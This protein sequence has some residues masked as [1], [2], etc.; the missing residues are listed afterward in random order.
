VEEAERKGMASQQEERIPA[1]LDKLVAQLASE[2]WV[3]KV[4]ARHAIERQ[5]EAAV[6]M[7]GRALQDARPIVRWEAAKAL[8]SVASVKAV[9]SLL[10]ALEDEN[11]GVRWLAAEALIA[12][13]K[14]CVLP[15]LHRLLERSGSP[16]Y[17][18]GAHHVLRTV[19]HIETSPV[20][21]ALEGHFTT[22]ALPA[23][24]FQALERLEG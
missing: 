4:R 6:E 17:Q 10:A 12:A 2:D 11:G 18:E 5:G 20:V 15:L 13:G 9:P 19:A 3:T 16:W 8:R 21:E 14:P 1:E 7:L 22:E 23:P 24:V